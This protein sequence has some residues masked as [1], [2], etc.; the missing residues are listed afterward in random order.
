MK[1]LRLS[2]GYLLAAVL[3][4][5]CVPG[6]WAAPS[7]SVL[8]TF[9]GPDGANPFG[10]LA[11]NAA[12]NLFGT[13]SEGGSHNA[14]IVFELTPGKNGVW[15]EE[16]LHN[17]TGGYDGYGPY[18]GL[19]LDASG[20]IYGTATYGG[21]GG[22]SGG[23]GIVFKFTPNS[24][25]KWKENV[26][27][28]FNGLDG[29]KP[30]GTLILD[31][32]GNLYGTTQAGGH[33]GG[34]AVFELTQISGHRYW[35]ETLL[36]SFTIN[37]GNDPFAGLTFDTQGNLYGTTTGTVFKLTPLK[38]GKW[39]EA[40][41]YNFGGLNGPV[42]G[43]VVFDSAGNLY[44]TTYNG[45]RGFGEVYELTPSKG[46]WKETAIYNFCEG[47]CSGGAFPYAGLIIDEA[48]NLYGTTAG[49]NNVSG[50]VFELTPSKHVWKETEL[51]SFTGGTDGSSPIAGVVSDAAGN[52]YGTT[53]VGGNTLCQN[54]EGCG[55]VFRVSP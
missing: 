34:G 19:V 3:S 18:G 17:F 6:S 50:A 25:G 37:D 31:S 23:C 51:H 35:K 55:I 2:F 30:S 28:V 26:L 20:N 44:G 24:H 32:S 1:Q 16:V 4:V 5:I 10:S 9:T 53:L 47:S 11:M 21:G 15:K 45:G 46:N 48:G 54:N 52:L 36:H 13:T 7:E 43:G 39:K 41:L 27:Q 29:A 12:G 38:N 40:V 42:Y 8:Y 14:G 22:C 49:G 33:F